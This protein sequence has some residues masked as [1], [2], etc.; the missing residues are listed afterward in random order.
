MPDRDGRYIAE[1]V[2]TGFG[3]TGPNNLA[4]FTCRMKLL[5]ELGGESIEEVQEITAY[6]YIDKKDGSVNTTAVEQIH[7]AFGWDGR[8]LAWLAHQDLRGRRLQAT[9]G[10]E[11]WKG[12]HRLKVQW[13]DAENAKGAPQIKQADDDMMRRLN[14]RLGPKLRAG[15]KS[16]PAETPPAAPAKQDAP[17]VMRQD[18]TKLAT[19]V[20]DTEELAWERFTT[21][22]LNHGMK[23]PDVERMW[24]KAIDKIASG[25]GYGEI[26]GDEWQEISEHAIP[27]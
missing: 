6:L 24:N 19:N 26:T 17:T 20:Y 12:K 7:D 16:W 11:E 21:L 25:K 4:T 15:A 5:S 9:L 8:D 14:A 1:V 10:W 22:E 3:E 18:A 2:E 23:R 13:I 27:F